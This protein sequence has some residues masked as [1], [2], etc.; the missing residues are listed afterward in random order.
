MSSANRI[1]LL[2]DAL[3]YYCSLKRTR[4]GNYNVML[5]CDYPL[6]FV[7]ITEKACVNRYSNAV[8]QL[9]LAEDEMYSILQTSGIDTV[10][11][12]FDH[13]ESRLRMD[14][15]SRLR[16]TGILI[17]LQCE[18]MLVQTCEQILIRYK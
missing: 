11:A 1:D 12:D 3:S 10:T 13:I 18:N 14:E 5:A 8:K 16:G 9:K 17:H 2:T 7:F 15:E 4:L 6:L